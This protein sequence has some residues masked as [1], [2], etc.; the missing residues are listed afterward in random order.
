MA[1][2]FEGT[3]PANK[4]HIC[5]G[6]DGLAYYGTFFSAI[7]IV[8]VLSFCTTVDMA[9]SKG[10][11]IIP[12]NIEDENLLRSISKERK[13]I[14]AK[15]RNEP[16]ITLS[17]ASM[18]FVDSNQTI[19]L[20][21]LNG[22]TLIDLASHFEKPVFAGCFRNSQVLSDV[23]NFKKFF[24]TLF[25]AAGERYPNK[26]LR[27]SIEDY[28]GVG[29]ILACL[30]GEKTIEAEFAIQSFNTASSDLK[31]N[32]MACESGQELIAHGFRQDVELAA[33]YNFS[34]KISFLSRKD[35][36][37]QLI[38]RLVKNL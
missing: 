33:E 16:G 34:D 1:E 35:D 12:T 21:S 14:L 25:V 8:D 10:C 2:L 26:M 31:N 7:V 28:W 37:W 29:S 38:P 3:I 23:L 36:C 18:Q 24:P 22:S 27:P 30:E 13:A 15:K 19:L 4:H 6:Q 9:L 11:S 17:P 32:L 5:W 20:P